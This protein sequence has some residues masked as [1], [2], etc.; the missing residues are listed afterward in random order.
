LSSKGGAEAIVIKRGQARVTVIELTGSP[1]PSLSQIIDDDAKEA[2]AIV[3]RSDINNEDARKDSCNVL[4]KVVSKHEAVPA[5]DVPI[6]V[7]YIIDT[8][9]YCEINGRKF[10]TRLRNWD[11]DAQQEAYQR[12]ALQIA[13][14]LRLTF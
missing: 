12:I 13:R 7:P 9:F 5:A 3:S 11:G 1:F 4:R 6:R 2:V 8:D 10:T 14:T